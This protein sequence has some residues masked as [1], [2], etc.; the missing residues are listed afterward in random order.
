MNAIDLKAIRAAAEAASPGPWWH[1]ECKPAD[2]HA[3]AWLGQSFV[4]CAGGCRNYVDPALDAVYIATAN[5]AAILELLDRLEAA[6][7]DAARYRWMRDSEWNQ[8]THPDVWTQ[9]TNE[10]GELDEAIDAAMGEQK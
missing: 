6:E 1:G 7:K 10:Y 9:V 3:L 8:S 2:G 5:P 4:D